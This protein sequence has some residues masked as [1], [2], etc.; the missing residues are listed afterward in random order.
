VD[1]LRSPN[2]FDLEAQ[3]GK[4]ENVKAQRVGQKDNN[5]L[6]WLYCNP[7]ILFAKAL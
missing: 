6:L 4:S 3:N 1:C 5:K 2:S 7:N